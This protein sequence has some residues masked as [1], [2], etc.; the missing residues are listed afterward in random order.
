MN[1][2]PYRLMD[3]TPILLPDKHPQGIN[4]FNQI[5]ALLAALNLNLLTTIDDCFRMQCLVSESAVRDDF[6]INELRA[7]AK[8]LAEL[9]YHL[10]TSG[11]DKIP[12]RATA[13]L[14]ALIEPN[15]AKITCQMCSDTERAFYETLLKADVNPAPPDEDEVVL[16]SM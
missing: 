6:A 2:T 11:I 7:R 5:R 4:S 10:R 1:Y 16:L 12:E 3:G 14:R 13:R 15:I 8:Y 9:R